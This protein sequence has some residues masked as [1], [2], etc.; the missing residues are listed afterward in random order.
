MAQPAKE[1]IQRSRPPVEAP[2]PRWARKK[3]LVLRLEDVTESIR[4]TYPLFESALLSR[5]ISAGEQLAAA[6]NF[7]LNIKGASENGPAG[8]YE[9]YRHRFGV[10]QPLYGGGNVFA[11]YRVGRGF[12]QPWY[13][14][15]QTNDGGEFKAG[16]V[17]PL[18]QNRLIDDRRAA[19][20]RTTYGRKRVEPEIQAQLIEFLVFGSFAYWEWVAAGR[21]VEIAESLLELATQRQQ[22]LQERVRKGDVARIVLTDNERLI[23]S[24]QAKL[25]DARQKRRQAAVKLSLFLRRPDG[26]PFIPPNDLLPKTFPDPEPIDENQMTQDIQRAVANRPEFRVL[27][28][29]KRQLEVDLAQANNL[30]RPSLNA[31]FSGSQDVGQP[32]SSKRDKSEF[33]LEAGLYLTV[34]VQRRKAHGKIQAVEGKLAQLAIKRRF[35]RDKIVT[36]VQAAYA[37]LLAAYQ[38]IGQ[39]RRAYELA[40][41]MEAAER[42]KFAAGESNLL[43]VNLRESQTAQAGVTLV[44]ALM[45]YFQARAAYRAALAL[46]IVP[47]PPR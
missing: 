37:A 1:P 25:T 16:I 7:D 42:I 12:F 45:Q 31:V 6:G 39:A 22:G 14:E 17:V 43:D 29:L 20:W 26:T 35:T 47:P 9:T 2:K 23:V 19:L 41:T 15:R 8:F 3:Q 13:L 11:G 24:R 10:E 30:M 38:R 32:T 33:E 46:D 4:Q 18:S 36:E 28:L 27:A 34:P 5:K 40:R 44:E 21:N